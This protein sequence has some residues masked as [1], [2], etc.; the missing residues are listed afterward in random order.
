MLEQIAPLPA[1]A[2]VVDSFWQH[3]GEQTLRIL[4]DGCMDFIFD[5]VTRSHGLCLAERVAEAQDHAERRRLIADFLL[6]RTTRLRP[7]EPRIRRAVRHL[8]AHSGPG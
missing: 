7:P 3:D 8:R 2:G 5:E 6:G 4:P 1:L